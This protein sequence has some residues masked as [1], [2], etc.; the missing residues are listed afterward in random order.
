MPDV[1]VIGAGVIGTAVARSLTI[2]GASVVV[3]DRIG[4]ADGTSAATFSVDV[5]TRKTPREYFDLSLAGAH[6][7]ARLAAAFGTDATWHHPVPVYEWGGTERDRSVIRERVA[8][9]QAWSYPAEWIDHA[10]LLV[11]EP[12]LSVSPDEAQEVAAYPAGAWYDT[13]AFAR[14]MS[15]DAARL[16]ARFLTGHTVTGFHCSGDRIR[17]V[18][19]HAGT[20][21]AA[22]VVVD[23]AGPA[24][25]AVARLAGLDLPLLRIP[26]LVATTEPIDGPELRSVIMLPSVNLRPGGGGRLVIHSYP[27]D[28]VLGLDDPA[29]HAP[30]LLGHARRTVSGARERRLSRITVGVRPVPPDG[31]PLVG[32]LDEN[33]YVVSTHS[34]AHLAPILAALCV[35]EILGARVIQ[36]LAPFRPDRGTASMQ[37]TAAIDESLR[38]MKLQL[39]AKPVA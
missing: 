19:T 13:L 28:A 23:C 25:D 2:A 33:F 10:E 3:V 8:R 18:I 12:A 38:E 35:D 5:T 7:H 6:E 26:G 9:L 24:A 17:S 22:D 34:G 4:V 16:G 39:R 21:L 30:D 11:A 37:A 15:A 14:T 31:L 20:E 27:V 1:I 32:F 36:R 29:R